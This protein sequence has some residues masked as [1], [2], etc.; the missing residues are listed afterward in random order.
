MSRLGIQ[1]SR[2]GIRTQYFLVLTVSLTRERYLQHLNIKFVSPHG[3]VL[4]SIYN[5]FVVHCKLYIR[6]AIFCLIQISLLVFII[7]Y[8]ISHAAISTYKRRRDE[9]DSGKTDG[10]LIIKRSLISY[11]FLDPYSSYIVSSYYFINLP[12]HIQ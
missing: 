9:L 1:M 10:K 5:L 4:S 11:C 7:L 12:I 3:H 6:S 2:L 8:G